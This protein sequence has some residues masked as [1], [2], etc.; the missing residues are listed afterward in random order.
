[1]LPGAAAPVSPP[2]LTNDRFAGSG[3]ILNTQIGWDRVQDDVPCEPNVLSISEF[4]TWSIP[5][6]D[7]FASRTEYFQTGPLVGRPIDGAP[8]DSPFMN[9]VSYGNDSVGPYNTPIPCLP[10]GTITFECDYRPIYGS[11]SI[12]ENSPYGPIH[13]FSNWRMFI[14]FYDSAGMPAS[15]PWIQLVTWQDEET[16]IQGIGPPPDSP[17]IVWRHLAVALTVPYDAY[18]FEISHRADGA[19]AY[20]F[21]PP[22]AGYGP[23]FVP[24][25][26][27]AQGSALDIDNVLLTVVG[28]EPCAP[29][30]A[31]RW[32]ETHGVAADETGVYASTITGTS[33]PYH[34]DTAW[35]LYKYTPLGFLD[36]GPISIAGYEPERIGASDGYVYATFASVGVNQLRGMMRNASDGSLVWDRT[37]TQPKW[38]YAGAG[39]GLPGKG[40]G[41]SLYVLGQDASFAYEVALIDA[42][43]VSTIAVSDHAQGLYPHVDRTKFWLVTAPSG[44]GVLEEWSFS[45]GLIRTVNTG[46]SNVRGWAIDASGW[47]V[48]RHGAYNEILSG[49]DTTGALRWTVTTPVEANYEDLIASDGVVYAAGWTEHP[50]R[51]TGD[52]LAVIGLSVFSG[53][54]VMPLSEWG[55]DSTDG[56]FVED[57]TASGMNVYLGGAAFGPTYQGVTIPAL[58]GDLG[59]I[60]KLGSA[61][62]PMRG[63]G[64]ARV[65]G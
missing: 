25:W 41:A 55:A 28:Y 18:S 37:V 14:R 21:M 3:A 17:A 11:Y 60:H 1:M 50:E 22:I 8:G 36:W 16:S 52:M 23:I 62:I 9:T 43:S 12:W 56:G 63:S 51:P 59:F 57:I 19:P 15:I 65:E 48:A 58:A 13:D 64:A 31:N 10:L 42:L 39:F 34:Y 29:P 30:P 40:P 33:H 44:L 6:G 5:T 24:P 4:W 54:I 53:A 2:V 26:A 27:P 47:V 49:Y 35:S 7:P 45:G 32:S 61:G 38:W 46:I 20:V